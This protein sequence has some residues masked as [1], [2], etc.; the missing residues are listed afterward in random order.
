MYFGLYVVIDIY[1]RYVVARR[2][3][4]HE[5]AGLASEVLT[6]AMDRHQI[7][8]VVHADRGTSITS[9]PVAQLLVDLA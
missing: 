6:E 8:D 1:S 3:E 2:V 9:K 4:A 7:P 5:D